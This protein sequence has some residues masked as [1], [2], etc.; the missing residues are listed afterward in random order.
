MLLQEFLNDCKYRGITH[1]LDTNILSFFTYELLDA[2]FEDVIVSVLLEGCLKSLSFFIF[3]GI[4]I[5]YSIDK[6]TLLYYAIKSNNKTTVYYLLDKGANVHC[7]SKIDNFYNYTPIHIAAME[8]NKDIVDMLLVKG[9]HIDD[10]AYNN[11]TPLH[12]AVIKD[13]KEMIELLL[14]K[15]ANIEATNNY[16]FTP[17]QVAIR[18]NKKEI[19]QILFARG[20]NIETRDYDYQT[21]LHNAVDKGNIEIIELLLQKGA[22]YIDTYS[23]NNPAI[24]IIRNRL[25]RNNNI[26]SS[27]QLLGILPRDI[28]SSIIKFF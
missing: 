26:T 23:D 11:R 19:I 17:L 1:Y 22:K 16:K 12:M 25:E 8:G 18:G 10:N 24:I 27:L 13:Q 7:H 15:G 6:K 4:S 21:P 9:A 14:V 5:D 20:S 3:A 28:V 2:N